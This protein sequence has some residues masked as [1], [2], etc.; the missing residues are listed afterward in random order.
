MTEAG[1]KSSSQEMI[2]IIQLPNLGLLNIRVKKYGRT[3]HEYL[4]LKKGCRS[5]LSRNLDQ[6]SPKTGIS[7]N[8]RAEPEREGAGKR[9]R[10]GEN[11]T[12]ASGGPQGWRRNIGEGA[13]RQRAAKR[14]TSRLKRAGSLSGVPSAN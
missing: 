4:V 12:P 13:A 6:G 9:G 5:H 2:F 7:L 3:I 11:E 10:D 14:L 1:V 8:L